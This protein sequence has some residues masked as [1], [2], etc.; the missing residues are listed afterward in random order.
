MIAIIAILIGLLL[1]AVQKVRE[2]AARMQ[3]QN[4]L[5][6]IGLACHNH[7]SALGY[8]PTAGAQS[9]ANGMSGVGFETIGWCYQI[10]PYI[11]Q[12][13]LY[14][15]GQA[16]GVNW[17]ATIGK[18]MTDVPVKT[19]NC[20]S[21]SSRL[22][23]VASWGSVYAMG[24]Y[25]GVMVEWLNASDWQTTVPPRR[26]L[27]GLR[28]DDCQEA[29]CGPT[30]RHHPEVRDGERFRCSRRHVE[31]ASGRREGRLGPAV[32]AQ[33]LGLVGSSGLGP[34]RRLAEHAARR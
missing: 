32:H 17:N 2:A 8:F 1:P 33:G 29:A 7:E 30:T 23:Q 3:C 27:A 13:N 19:Y 34:R 20:P 12:D 31:H 11:E 25:A 28:R 18:A 4:N 9:A 14:K 26:H 24:D 21:R 6:Q 16:S 10:L 22:S 5:K 15:I